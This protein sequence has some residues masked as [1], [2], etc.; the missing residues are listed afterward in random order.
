M[1]LYRSGTFHPG[2][3]YG[4]FSVNG[5]AGRPVPAHKPSRW[6]Y[7]DGG[8]AGFQLSRNDDGKLIPAAIVRQRGNV[9]SVSYRRPRNLSR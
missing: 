3:D 7:R 1:L 5:R 8:S 2:R 9:A 6:D 4:L